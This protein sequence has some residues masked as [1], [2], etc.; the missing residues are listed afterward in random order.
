MNKLSLTL[1]TFLLHSIVIAQNPGNVGTGNLTA[2][3]MPDALGLGNVTSW[4]TTFPTGGSAT[5][6]T[7]ASAPYPQATNVPAGDVSNYNTTLEFTANT[8]AS[9]KALQN[10]SSPNFLNNIKITE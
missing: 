7:D 10:T 2:W 8:T 3:F 1:T 6:V 9:L 4:T 5:T